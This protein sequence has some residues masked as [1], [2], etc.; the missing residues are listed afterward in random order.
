M[1]GSS[2]GSISGASVGSTV[3]S[4]VAS[5]TGASVGSTVGTP[6]QGPTFSGAQNL[7]LKGC[8]SLLS[9][10]CTTCS[11]SEWFQHYA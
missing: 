4:L 1:V 7:V 8:I 9:N 6:T 3:C 2:A 11:L 5:T 10:L